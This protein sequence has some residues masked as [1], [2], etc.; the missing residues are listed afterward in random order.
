MKPTPGGIIYD[1]QKKEFR[2][3]PIYPAVQ[4]KESKYLFNVIYLSIAL[5]KYLL[6]EPNDINGVKYD[7]DLLC[8]YFGIGQDIA[9]LKRE[10]RI[11]EII[12]SILNPTQ[13]QLAALVEV[14]RG[15][16]SNPSTTI[17]LSTSSKEVVKVLFAIDT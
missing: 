10:G 7:Q 16:E 13:A 2:I 17:P 5:Y 4:N 8:C 12:P 3:Y 14:E 15:N 11:R 6:S 9:E 1:R